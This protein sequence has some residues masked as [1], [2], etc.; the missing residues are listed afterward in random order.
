VAVD[1]SD[2]YPFHFSHYLLRLSDE[3]RLPF[4]APDSKYSLW[5]D[6]DCSVAVYS[7]LN[8][9]LFD[10]ALGFELDRVEL[11]VLDYVLDVADA[12]VVYFVRTLG[13]ALERY[14]LEC[15][16]LLLEHVVLLPGHVVPD[17]HQA[18]ADSQVY[19]VAADSAP[20]D[21]QDS[22][23]VDWAVARRTRSPVKSDSHRGKDWQ[24][25]VHLLA[26]MLL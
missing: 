8:C 13:Y 1:D 7:G 25:V 6:A 12:A 2:M 19:Q 5:L 24:A 14:E 18:Y 22:E 17:Y 15:A 11:L 21:N 23:Q 20:D 10:C 3:F 16:A 9:R 4:F 26:G